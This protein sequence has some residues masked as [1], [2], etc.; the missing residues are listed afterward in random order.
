MKRTFPEAILHFSA[1][2]T[3]AFLPFPG[4]VPVTTASAS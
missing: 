4:A 1:P 2:A 3:P